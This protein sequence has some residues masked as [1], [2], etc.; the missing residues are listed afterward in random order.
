MAWVF[1]LWSIERIKR[2]TKEFYENSQ[3][4]LKEKD[5]TI[6]NLRN[7]ISVR[8]RRITKLENWIKIKKSPKRLAKF[9]KKL[10]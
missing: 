2:K 8:N 1:I 4:I 7:K 9:Q 6:Q 5:R 10:K 3:K